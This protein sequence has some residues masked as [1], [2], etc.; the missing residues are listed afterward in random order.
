MLKAEVTFTHE[1]W[2]KIN[3]EMDSRFAHLAIVG[4]YHSHPDFGVFLS[5]RDLQ[6]G[7]GGPVSDP[8]RVLSGFVDGIMMRTFAHTE[9][10]ELAPAP[11]D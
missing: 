1:T 6:I 2:N 4:W 5:D 11:I 9:V 3:A 7:R 10:V 8:A